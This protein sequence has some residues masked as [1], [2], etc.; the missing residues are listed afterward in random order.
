MGL[1]TL[2][3]WIALALANEWFYLFLMGTMMAI[4]SFA[5]DFLIENLQE[6]HY[7]IYAS[8]SHS[9]IASLML[10]VIFAVVLVFAAVLV[11]KVSFTMAS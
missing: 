3:K 9:Y 1:K 10:W 2:T 5:I 11:T 6:V 7:I 8:N 4:L